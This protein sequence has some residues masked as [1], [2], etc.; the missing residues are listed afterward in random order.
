[1]KEK[2][3][4]KHVWAFVVPRFA[5]AMHNDEPAENSKEGKKERKRTNRKSQERR[6]HL[7]VRFSFVFGK[8]K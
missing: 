1:M 4:S 5:K 3:K 7:R 8:A 2:K 6:Y